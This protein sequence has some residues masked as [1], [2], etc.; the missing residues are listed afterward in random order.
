MKFVIA[1]G[2]SMIGVALTELLIKEGHEVFVI[3]RE[4]SATRDNIPQGKNVHVVSYTGLDDFDSTY[5]KI[6]NANVWVHLSWAGAGHGG[7]DNK[8]LQDHNVKYSLQ[9]VNVA[10]RLGCKVFVEAGSQAEYGF[11]TDLI[12]ETTPCHPDNEYGRAKLKFGELASEKCKIYGMKSIHL[13]IFSVFGEADQEWTLVRSSIKKMLKN[14]DVELSSC[15]QMWN[16]V[17]CRDAVKQIYF[18]VLHAMKNQNFKSEIFNIA[19]DDTRQLKDFI[20][21]M[22]RL[23]NSKSKLLYGYYKPANVMSLNPDVSKTKMATGGFI[24]DYTFSEVIN[25]IIKLENKK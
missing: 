17:Y 18:L 16:F 13:R 3:C 20:N 5:S 15:E 14:E 2:S 8:K 9:A 21:E 10:N 19:S 24:S 4:T 22:Y 6:L 12:S 23:T 7:R 25:R 11:V 1:G